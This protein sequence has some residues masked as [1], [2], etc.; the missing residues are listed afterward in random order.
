MNA[1]LDMDATF[2]ALAHE[3]RRRILD[4]VKSKPGITVGVIST[5]FDVSR[6]AIM[7]HL[8]VLEDANLLTSEKDGRSRRFYF[9][10][11]PNTDDL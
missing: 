2:Q 6:I 9:N 7:K 8:A 4:L 11:Y 5:E 3:S 10:Q 1:D